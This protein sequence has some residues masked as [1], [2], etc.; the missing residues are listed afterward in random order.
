M[1][2]KGHFR[3]LVFFV[4]ALLACSTAA[5]VTLRL[6]TPARAA[7]LLT[8]LHVVGNQIQDSSGNVFVPHGADR[9]GTEYACRTAGWPTTFDGPVDQAAVSAMLTRDINS[10][11][12][13]LNEDCWLGINGEPA[14]GTTVQQYQTDIINWVNLLNQN[15]LV[16]ILELHWNAPGS[17]QSLGQQPMPDLDHAPAF[18]TSVA[19][20]FKNNSS[21]IFDLYNEPYPANNTDSPMGWSCWRDGST[22]ANTNPCPEINFAAAGMQTLINTVRATGATNILM[23]GGLQYANDL[24]SWLAYE[25]TDPDNNL[26]ASAH[27]YNFNVCNNT[28]CYDS[29]IAPV[30]AKVPVITGEIGEDDCASTFITPLMNWLDA[31]GI[32]YL[33]WTWTTG[34]CN[35]ISDY[36]GI[37]TNF[38]AGY[39]AHLLSLGGGGGSTP[40]STASVGTTPTPTQSSGGSSCHVVY[41]IVNQWTGGF[42]GSISIT[43]TGSS[44]IN[45]WSLVFSFANEQTITQIWNASASQSGSQITVTNLSYDATIAPGSTLS[46]VG[47]LGSWNGTNTAPTS[48]TLNGVACN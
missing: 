41:T 39:K 9:M 8:G 36:S 23:L 2:S 18:W 31:H 28:S 42:Q 40:T 24:R 19:N 20:T 22:A 44:I 3:L 17:S 16:V 27:I 25:P 15:G 11:R 48:F 34:G 7:S 5:V 38:G 37:P 45:G 30:A 12:V 33:A 13:P 21:V 32:G 1:Q 29:Q 14:N 46:S 6:P 47:F 10:V 26:V 43:N 4:L 35:L